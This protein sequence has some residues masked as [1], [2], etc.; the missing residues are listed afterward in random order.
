TPSAV[1]SAISA[2]EVWVVGPPRMGRT[3][4]HYTDA[5]M[6]PVALALRQEFGNCFVDSR[7]VPRVDGDGIHVGPEGGE[8]WASYVVAKMT[9]GGS[10][11]ILGMAFLFAGVWYLM[12][13]K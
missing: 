12:Q 11:A 2:R 4:G 9:P 5:T 7:P 3:T 13:R 6:A 1:V 8:A 10:S